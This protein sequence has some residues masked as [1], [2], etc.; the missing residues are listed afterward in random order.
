MDFE[1]VANFDCSHVYIIPWWA[2]TIAQ[3]NLDISQISSTLQ[4]MC[5]IT[6][7]KPVQSSRLPNPGPPKRLLKYLL[8][9][10]F[11][12]LCIPL[13]LK[14]I[15]LRTVSNKITSQLLQQ[16]RRNRYHAILLPL[17]LPNKQQASIRLYIGWFDI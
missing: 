7:S 5:A 12:V 2:A 8:Y 1:S 6:V 13:S 16:S 14:Q 15:Q 11:T 3:Q 4:Q 17:S 10:L 9:A